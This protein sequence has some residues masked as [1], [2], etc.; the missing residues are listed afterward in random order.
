M[1]DLQQILEFFENLSAI[2]L[3]MNLKQQGVGVMVC[4]GI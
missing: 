4:T 2:N 3:P 1:F